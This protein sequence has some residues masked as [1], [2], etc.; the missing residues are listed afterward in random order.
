[1]KGI[2]SMTERFEEKKMEDI[3]GLEKG[4]KQYLKEKGFKNTIQRQAVLEILIKYEGS[5]LSAE[6]VY[7]KLIESHP[8]IG[9]A[10]VY[11]TLLLFVDMGVCCKHDFDDGLSRY[12]LNH[13]SEYHRHHHLIC[14]LCGGIS[15][16][17]EDLL[18]G[19]E[20]Q[21]RLKNN[22]IVKNHTLKFY[23]VCKTCQEKNIVEE[24]RLK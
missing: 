4:L 6:E 5:H 15:E 13:S 2:Y 8:E 12:E 24:M 14:N 11:R 23:G 1:M 3:N 9:I 21:I 19:L 17:Q 20:D 7:G 18:D 22:F 16:V 10:T